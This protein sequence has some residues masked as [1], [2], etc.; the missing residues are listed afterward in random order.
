M[1]TEERIRAVRR[2]IDQGE[3][4]LDA[5]AEL[6][7]ELSAIAEEVA[8]AA[9]LSPQR[10]TGLRPPKTVSLRRSRCYGSG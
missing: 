10:R 5:W 4:L 1:R 3:V 8:D 2:V 9:Y 6:G 7:D